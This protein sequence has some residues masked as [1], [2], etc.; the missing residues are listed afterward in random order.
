MEKKLTTLLG[1]YWHERRELVSPNDPP[2][3]NQDDY[4][5]LRTFS[6]MSGKVRHPRVRDLTER[7]ESTVLP[8]FRG[9]TQEV[10]TPLPERYGH[11]LSTGDFG[12]RYAACE[13][14]A[15]QRLTAQL[16]LDYEA[17]KQ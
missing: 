9:W 10:G 6:M 13:A 12:R 4:G 16:K 8:L 17:W 7:F 2:H 3:G 5:K 1:R 15:I 11:E 14:R